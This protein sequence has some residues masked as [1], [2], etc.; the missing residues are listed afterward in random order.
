MQLSGGSHTAGVT[1]LVLWPAPAAA[2]QRSCLAASSGNTA[3]VSG[4]TFRRFTTADAL[5][6]ATLR[7]RVS[8]SVHRLP[9][10][11]CAINLTTQAGRFVL[12]HQHR[13]SDAGGQPTHLCNFG[14][15]R[16]DTGLVHEWTRHDES[17]LS[18]PV[19]WSVDSNTGA[20]SGI[21]LN[22]IGGAGGHHQLPPQWQH[23]QTQPLS[24]LTRAGM[25]RAVHQRPRAPASPKT[26]VSC[27]TAG[28]TITSSR[29]CLWT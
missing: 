22:C 3:T 13:L 14:R 10:T 25:T 17:C 21:E 27:L 5:R 23:Q 15:P 16:W 8:T 18:S 6:P 7:T 29:A 28:S 9:R 20:C 24:S 12:F 26:S 11:H 1:Q 19:L 4:V 2:M